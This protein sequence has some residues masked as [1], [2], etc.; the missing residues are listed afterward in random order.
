[1]KNK[2]E[3]KKILSAIIFF[4]AVLICFAIFPLSAFALD[5]SDIPNLA[6]GKPYYYVDGKENDQWVLTENE[7]KHCDIVDNSADLDAVTEK[8]RHEMINRNEKITIYIATKADGYN[9]KL[10]A[11]DID[12]N[13]QANDLAN[14]NIYKMFSQITNSLYQT[15]NIKD[16][17]ER[18]KSGSYLEMLTKNLVYTSQSRRL[19]A[20]DSSEYSYYKLELDVKYTS[21]AQMENEVDSFL[22]KW[23]A[24][25]IDSNAVIQNA[26]TI[27]EKNYYIVKTIYNY[28]AH[29]TLYDEDVYQYNLSREKSFDADKE[30][31]YGPDSGQFRNS[32]SAYGALFGNTVDEKGVVDV[33]NYKWETTTDSMGLCK[34]SNYNQGLS[35]CDG[36]SLVTYYLCQ[37][38][39]IDCKIVQG[40]YVEG[41]EHSS[42]PHAWNVIKLCPSNSDLY[43]TDTAKWYHYDATYA[44]T[45]PVFVKFSSISIVDYA[46]F[47]RGYANASYNIKSHQQI[48]PVFAGLDEKDYVLISDSIDCSKAW[49]VLTR[50]KDKNNYLEIEN[51]FIISPD[52][53]YYKINPNTFALEECKNDVVYDGNEYFYNLNI[54]DFANGIEYTCDEQLLKDSQNCNFKVFSLDGDNILYELNFDISPLD[55]SNW[56]GYSKLLWNGDD[57]FERDLNNYK[58]SIPFMGSVITFEA[59]IYDVANKRL[60]EGCEY[61]I[62]CKDIYGNT[63]EPCIPG[64]Y[65]IEINFDIAYDNYQG[66]LKIYF[67]ITKGDI[68]SIAITPLDNLVYGSDVVSGCGSLN[69]VGTDIMLYNGIDYYVYLENPS[70]LNYGNEGYVVYVVLPSCPYFREGTSLRRYYRIARQADISS[71]FNGKSSNSVYNYTGYAIMPNTFSLGLQNPDGSVYML[72]ENID[73]RIL[74][75]SNNVNV[76]TGYVTIQFIG[77]YCGTATMSFQIVAS[78]G[79]SNINKNESNTTNQ[80]NNG[81]SGNYITGNMPNISVTLKD[82][83]TYTGVVQ[84]PAA[85]VTADGKTLTQG[86][87]YVVSTIPA[88]VGVYECTVQGIGDY[89]YFNVKR[90]V[91]VAPAKITGGKNSSSAKTSV[92]ISWNGQGNNCFYEIYVYDTVKKKWTLMAITNQTSFKTTYIIKNNKKSQLKANTQCKFRI[93]GYYFVQVNNVTYAKYGAYSATINASTLLITPTSPKASKGKK[94]FKVTWKKASGAAGYEIQYATDSK[95]KKNK[96][97]VTI[98]NAKTTSATVK[99]LKSGK[100]YYIRIRAYKKVN[101]KK[102]YSGYTKT[103]KIKVK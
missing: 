90:A 56:N 29:N 55:M 89:S 11:S 57:I 103:I 64:D 84:T 46:Y 21:T 98:K 17:L 34:I 28:L 72:Q 91:F 19:G 41:A 76:G 12:Y 6:D 94:S 37:L 32:H 66:I 8:V 102:V 35:V 74:S 92:T 87:D 80:Q 20:S 51:Y 7:W 18:A 68:S 14:A 42:D 1:M 25:F 50:R 86:V 85:S 81:G 45:S 60:T 73:Y 15:D 95:F 97:T 43:N 77:N 26:S 24:E 61:S 3:S 9:S 70:A 27:N 22:S 101:G 96:K 69:F 13:E 52:N 49:S 47:L 65:C 33:S 62:S 88:D 4:I 53:K 16:N 30:S 44:A 83:L 54:Q 39:G 48:S 67:T 63:V 5:A 71:Q 2:T 40:D 36:Y 79:S 99:K 23:Q 82:T 75:Y 10:N 78:G 38:N 31:L 59:E 58:P 93:R 100:T